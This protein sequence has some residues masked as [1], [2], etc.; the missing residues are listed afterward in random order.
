MKA[1]VIH[2]TVSVYK[3]ANA[4][5]HQDFINTRADDLAWIS[6]GA[7]LLLHDG[8][9]EEAKDGN[10]DGADKLSRSLSSSMSDDNL[11]REIA[12]LDNKAKNLNFYFLH[13]LQHRQVMMQLPLRNG[14]LCGI[15]N[16]RPVKAR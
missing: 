11:E 1:N 16:E 13:L 10:N 8:N 4:S 9:K 5:K 6:K 7:V 15:Y 14:Q 12:K 2:V 3:K